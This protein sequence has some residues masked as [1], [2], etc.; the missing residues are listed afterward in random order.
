MFDIGVDVAAMEAF[1]GYV[2]FP[3][4]LVFAA[5]VEFIRIAG[6]NV[7]DA[8]IEVKLERTVDVPFR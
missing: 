2:Q 6:T 4:V 5:I 7:A 3:W 1:T 8:P